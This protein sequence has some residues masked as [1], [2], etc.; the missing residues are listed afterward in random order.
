MKKL[1]GV[2]RGKPRY[3]FSKFNWLVF[4]FLNKPIFWVKALLGKFRLYQCE[5]LPRDLPYLK[6][7]NI[8][9]KR[10]LS[11]GR[12]VVSSANQKKLISENNLPLIFKGIDI[13]LNFLMHMQLL[14]SVASTNSGG[15]YQIVD[16]PLLRDIKHHRGNDRNKIINDCISQLEPISALDVGANMGLL[17][18]ALLQKGIPTMSVEINHLYY[19]I[20]SYRLKIYDQSDSFCGSIFNLPHYNYDLVIALS[21]FHHFLITEEMLDNLIAFLQ[22]LNCRYMLFEPHQSKHGFDNAFVDFDEDEFCQFICDNSVL[23]SYEK[24]A[25]SFRQRPI[26]LL[27]A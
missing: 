7:V 23:I 19:H 25:V 1:L 10:V 24:I 3:M 8:E 6:I 16:H 15:L 12:L 17:S 18:Q 26:Y 13:H 11:D 27:R 20:M 2:L 5:V 21:I 14:R 4:W 9:A 22:G